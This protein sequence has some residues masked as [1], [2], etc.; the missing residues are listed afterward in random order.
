MNLER[1]EMSPAIPPL[2]QHTLQVA[3]PNLVGL[4]CYTVPDIHTLHLCL[5]RCSRL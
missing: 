4:L 3:Y 5:T 1:Q 2:S